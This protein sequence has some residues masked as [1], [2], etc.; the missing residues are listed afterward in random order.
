VILY[1]AILFIGGACRRVLT[2]SLFGVAKAAEP[3]QPHAEKMIMTIRNGVAES[4][5]YSE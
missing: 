5:A 2:F 4:L 1:E 3:H